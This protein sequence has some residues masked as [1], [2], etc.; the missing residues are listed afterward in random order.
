MDCRWPEW[1]YWCSLFIFS[2]EMDDIVKQSLLKELEEEKAN[3]VGVCVCVH[4]SVFITSSYGNVN[5]SSHSLIEPNLTEAVRNSK[6]VSS[7]G[8][9]D[10]FT[11]E[12]HF[13][14]LTH[15]ASVA[16][17]AGSGVHVG[18]V[19]DLHSGADLWAEEPLHGAE[20]A[21]PKGAERGE[22]SPGQE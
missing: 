17:T 6:K 22:T 3:K 12:A 4:I 18:S 11:L 19:S 10:S 13:L 21:E 1:S 5:I 15:C 14:L 9:S 20:R 16:Q 7:C 2:V 8:Q